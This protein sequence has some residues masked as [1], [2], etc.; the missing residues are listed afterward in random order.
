MISLFPLPTPQS[1]VSLQRTRGSGR[2]SVK[3]SAAESR[4][5]RLFQEGSARIRIP[6]VQPGS[7]LEAVLINTA[8]GLTGGDI[9]DWVFEAGEGAAMVLAT[10]ACEKTYKAQGTS[11]AVVSVRLKL[12]PASSLAWLPQETILFDRARLTRSIEVDMAAGSRLLMVEPV[13]FGRLAMKEAVIEG[14]FRDR[15]RIR[16]GGHLLHAEDMRLGPNIADT[17]TRGAVTGGGLAIATV[18]MIAPDAEAKLAAVRALIGASGGVSFVT[19]RRS[20]PTR[21]ETGKL[22]ARIVASD[23]YELRKILV[24]LIRLLNPSGGVPKVWSI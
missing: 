5:D 1:S 2:L 23:S 19:A 16:H 8:G 13:V 12:G 17:L 11:E 15:W 7:P 6:R 14:Q 22:L 4:I 10:Q 18:L 24:P 3:L 9:M 20:N 21:D